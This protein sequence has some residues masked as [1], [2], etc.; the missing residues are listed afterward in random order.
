MLTKVGLGQVGS[1]FSIMCWIGLGW[2]IDMMGWIELG[3]ANLDPCPSLLRGQ[4]LKG[5]GHT[6]IK[7][8]VG[9]GLQVN[10][11]A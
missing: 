9:V 4:K 3:P 6:V 7:C 1:I 2:V 11:T 8:N 10:M 5:Q